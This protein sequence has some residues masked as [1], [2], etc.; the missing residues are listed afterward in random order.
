MHS[1]VSKL[2]CSD[3]QLENKDWTLDWTGLF[4]HTRDVIEY[5]CGRPGGGIKLERR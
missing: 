5:Y 3:G 1:L 4:V 2:C